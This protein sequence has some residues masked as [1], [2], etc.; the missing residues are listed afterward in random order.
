MIKTLSFLLVILS[1]LLASCGSEPSA[2]PTFSATKTALPTQTV[3]ATTTPRP[4]KDLSALPIISVENA[5][6]VVELAVL[7]GHTGWVGPVVFSPDGEML[8]STGGDGKVRLWDVATGWRRGR[9]QN[10]EV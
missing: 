10:R 7:Y 9:F 3:S 1:A 6:Q 5:D 4:T 2:S 8:A